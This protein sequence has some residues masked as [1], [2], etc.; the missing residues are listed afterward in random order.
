MA[1]HPNTDIMPAREQAAFKAAYAA[2]RA[3]SDPQ[4]EKTSR[5]FATVIVSAIDAGWSQRT[6]AEALGITRDKTARLAKMRDVPRIKVEPHSPGAGFPARTI[7]AYRKVEDEVNLRRILTERTFAGA[8]RAANAAGWSNPRLGAIVGLTGERM[9]QIADM[10]LSTYGTAIPCFTPYTK[11]TKVQAHRPGRPALGAE[12]AERMHRLAD[13]ARKATKRVGKR[14]GPAPSA[15]DIQ[16]LEDAL[17]ARK[18]SEELSGLIMAARGRGVP[19]PALDAACGY[20]RGSAQARAVRHG[21]GEGW[22]SVPAYSPTDATVHQKLAAA[23][24]KGLG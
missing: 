21:Y 20:A 18:A 10:D 24:D 4:D 2:F 6:V 13:V 5:K 17:A 1:E 23:R 12:E 22:A 16:E 8:V 11:Q 14:L 3:A 19:W 15:E 7:A 9:R